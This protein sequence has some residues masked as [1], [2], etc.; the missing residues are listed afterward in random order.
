M[1]KD[2]DKNVH[3]SYVDMIKQ[4]N[5]LDA[6]VFAKLAESDGGYIEA[7]ALQ[8]KLTYRDAFF[9]SPLLQWFVGWTLESYNVFDISTCLIRLS[10][11]GIIDLRYNERVEKSGYEELKNSTLITPI[12][13]EWELNVN[14]FRSILM[15]ELRS[16]FMSELRSELE[17]EWWN[18]LWNELMSKSVGELRNGTDL[19]I[20]EN[21]LFVNEF[22]RRFA[23][24]CLQQKPEN[25]D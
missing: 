11:L 18:E 14:E 10:R 1:N 9:K 15:S 7:I 4:M 16:K 8:I 5:H 21:T 23:D 3:P 22:G 12:Y 6:I 19:V 13:D 20:I 24:A 17:N 2:M 25:T